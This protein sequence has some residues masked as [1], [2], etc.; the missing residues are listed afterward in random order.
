MFFVV[1]LLHSYLGHPCNAPA[2]LELM[3]L[4][5][6]CILCWALRTEESPENAHGV[7]I[8]RPIPHGPALASTEMTM[9]FTKDMDHWDKYIYTPSIKRTFD[10]IDFP[11]VQKHMTQTG[12]IHAI[13]GI[14]E[15]TA[16]GG[17][18]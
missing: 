14:T 8:P 17:Q 4:F 5:S 18:Q 3:M 9:D 7:A 12:G 15:P 1:A 16:K 10:F 13:T 2:P 11:L 6:P